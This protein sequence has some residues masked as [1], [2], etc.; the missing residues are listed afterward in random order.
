[1][2]STFVPV[3]DDIDSA[4]SSYYSQ[5]NKTVGGGAGAGANNAQTLLPQPP[6]GGNGDGYD[7]AA[8][9]A[10]RRAD[11]DSI[12]QQSNMV[13]GGAGAVTA[14]GGGGVVMP[15]QRSSASA[16]TDAQKMITTAKELASREDLERAIINSSQSLGMTPEKIRTLFDELDK[17]RNEEVE[18]KVRV[19]PAFFRPARPGAG[20]AL[21]DERER[22]LVLQSL[23]QESKR[24]LDM[25][26]RGLQA[27][28]QIEKARLE[29][30][31]RDVF[32]Y[33]DQK[34]KKKW[35][36]TQTMVIG[37]HVQTRDEFLQ[38]VI[39][40]FAQ[41]F[42]D[43]SRIRDVLAKTLDKASFEQIDFTFEEARIISSQ[44]DNDYFSEIG[45]S[46][47][48]RQNGYPIMQFY[49]FVLTIESTYRL[50]HAMDL[51]LSR[52]DRSSELVSSLQR[53]ILPEDNRPWV[54]RRYWPD[55][56]KIQS[57]GQ[58]F[59]NDDAADRK[60]YDVTIGQR[61]DSTET[62]DPHRR[63]I[64]YCEEYHGL[65]NDPEA[66]KKYNHRDDEASYA[67]KPFLDN[68]TSRFK[69]D[70]PWKQNYTRGNTEYE[71]ACHEALLYANDVWR[72][73]IALSQG[74]FKVNFT[75]AKEFRMPDYSRVGPVDTVDEPDAFN[76]TDGNSVKLIE[77]GHWINSFTGPY[78]LPSEL[79][80]SCLQP[81]YTDI[82]DYPC[83]TFGRM[84]DRA[85][86]IEPGMV[87]KLYN[88]KSSDIDAKTGFP[89]V[90]PVLGSF[91]TS[92]API[93]KSRFKNHV[94]QSA[95]VN[96]IGGGPIGRYNFLLQSCENLR[97]YSRKF[98]VDLAKETTATVK[99]RLDPNDDVKAGPILSTSN[100]SQQGNVTL[101]Y[102]SKF[103]YH[104]FMPLRP[105]RWP[106]N[107]EQIATYTT[108]QTKPGMLE[109]HAI[110][111]DAGTQ[112]FNPL[113][114]Q[115]SNHF[116]LF[117]HAKVITW[118]QIKT[119]MERLKKHPI[120]VCPRL[121]DAYRKSSTGELLRARYL[122]QL[123]SRL[124]SHVKRLNTDN[125]SLTNL[126]GTMKPSEYTNLFLPK[127]ADGEIF[128]FKDR[129]GMP[130][131]YDKAVRFDPSTKSMYM[132]PSVDLNRTECATRVLAPYLPG[133]T[134][135]E[136]LAALLKA[137]D[138]TGT[139]DMSELPLAR[140]LVSYLNQKVSTEKNSDMQQMMQRVLAA[141]EQKKDPS[142]EI[143]SNISK[144][145][146]DTLTKN[147]K[148]IE[149]LKNDGTPNGD[150]LR[151]LTAADPEKTELAKT[152]EAL[153][154]YTNLFAR[155]QHMQP[156]N[157]NNNLY[158]RQPVPLP[159]GASQF[160]RYPQQPP[161]WNSLPPNAGMFGGPGFV[162]AGPVVDPYNNGG[163]MRASTIA[164]PLQDD[165]EVVRVR[166]RASSLDD[167]TDVQRRRLSR[168]NAKLNPR[169]QRME[170]VFLG[171]EKPSELLD[172]SSSMRAAPLES[173]PSPFQHLSKRRTSGHGAHYEA[174]YDI[175]SRQCAHA[176]C[177][178]NICHLSSMLN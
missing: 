56:R 169:T 173:S 75:N 176:T 81:K 170:P 129:D 152:L 174:D 68:L 85:D 141:V 121:A 84:L 14:G 93:E 128:V 70:F 146:A 21:S 19:D 55:D 136:H 90:T 38:R 92:G 165:R 107:M 66:M 131:P 103:F 54:F 36:P 20:K 3:N 28:E 94:H 80:A 142:K 115:P 33:F 49:D 109:I 57:I 137:N 150:I 88:Y 46:P 117:T 91:T 42:F 113:T 64:W 73:L 166:I 112:L 171:P 168:M 164:A 60:S 123:Q 122:V 111:T 37:D 76:P 25:Q 98:A 29:E 10:R 120:H 156:Y 162:S 132:D 6:S 97:M 23:A 149:Q 126:G 151:E 41:E 134:G 153:Q 172:M 9:A 147:P 116:S 74:L 53:V 133:V 155:Q 114:F 177:P 69:S 89:L 140:E 13:G 12:L 143:Q 157:N 58:Y 105:S 118:S 59:S 63:M 96:G 48:V 83:N 102:S 135:K 67:P 108:A 119:Q 145:V 154:M 31:S 35:R 159:M 148:L 8:E 100:I 144:L 27:A 82:R 15:Q 158:R 44:N 61:I 160:G 5:F 79:D 139:R 138:L 87:E 130:V 22:Y 51:Q 52:I 50:M 72:N 106:A 39:R 178:D 40:N 47:D 1:M 26:D 95:S 16:S 30:K 124:A 62:F 77:T 101:K 2:S 7:L 4:A 125:V 24:N 86:G 127:C 65:Y 71:M 110:P 11:A 104:P 99:R 167:M 32:A 45:S 17:R 163:R 175:A 34:N 78:G 161:A 18:V 43:D